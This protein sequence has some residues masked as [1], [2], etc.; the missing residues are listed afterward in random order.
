MCMGMCIG[1]GM[2][3]GVGMGVSSR[4]ERHYSPHLT[5][6]ATLYQTIGINEENKRNNGMYFFRSIP[7][8]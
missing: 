2:D 8:I 5:Q 6:A 3:M 7:S 4:V 1:M